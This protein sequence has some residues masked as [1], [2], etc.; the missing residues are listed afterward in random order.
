MVPELSEY[1]ST[2]IAWEIL[3][4]EARKLSKPAVEDLNTEYG[5]KQVK[6]GQKL[7]V[8]SESE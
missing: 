1:L 6:I 7:C 5:K 2:E 8:D 3:W 4:D